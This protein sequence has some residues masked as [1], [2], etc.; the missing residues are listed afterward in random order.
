M[1][2]ALKTSTLYELI[3]DLA[4][5]MPD[6]DP[7]E[8]AKTVV[9]HTPDESLIDFYTESLVSVIRSHFTTRRNNAIRDV[10]N[11]HPK[12][13]AMPGGT[14]SSR[15]AKGLDAWTKMRDSRV[16]VN[17]VLTRLGA[18]GVKELSAAISE[19]EEHIADVAVKV[20]QYRQMIA[21]LEKYRADV[22]DDIPPTIA[23]Q[24]LE[25]KS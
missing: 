11:P 6:A 20:E 4:D 13:R 23:Q 25:E 17:G 1:T 19:R 12:G 5:D 10:F 21:L 9:A 15:I 22:L 3:R 16:S 14:R 8:I 18:C 24:F 7:R 2:A